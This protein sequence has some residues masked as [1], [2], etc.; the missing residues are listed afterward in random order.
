LVRAVTVQGLVAAVQVSPPL[1]GVVESVAVTV[2]DVIAEPPVEAGAVQETG[3]WAF[4][5]PV[6]LT[7]VGGPGGSR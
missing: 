4:R 2:Y 1:A 6:A 7:A 3:A 5:P